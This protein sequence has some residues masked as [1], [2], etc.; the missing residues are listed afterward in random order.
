MSGASGKVPAAIHVSPEAKGG[1][2]LALL[3]DGDL[4]RVCAVTGQLE[5]VIDEDEWSFRTAAEEPKPPYDTGRELF[6]LMRGTCDEA[7]RGASAM[8]AAMDSEID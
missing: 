2:P 8:L 4:V 1:G 3:R 6:A 7:E 5:V